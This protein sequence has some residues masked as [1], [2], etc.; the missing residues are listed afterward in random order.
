[1]TLIPSLR[2]LIIISPIAKL[3]Y[4]SLLIPL[5]CTLFLY[6]RIRTNL[7]KNHPIII[8]NICLW[9]LVPDHLDFVA[10]SPLYKIFLT[11]LKETSA[12]TWI[13]V[14]LFLTELVLNQFGVFL[15]CMRIVVQKKEQEDTL[16]V[17]GLKQTT[18]HNLNKNNKEEWK[19]CN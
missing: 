13:K 6:N 14:K 7:I 17:K 18:S 15:F 1:M 9:I 3:F 5:P 12:A 11:F 8:N 4:S 2:K 10:I 16:G 19:T